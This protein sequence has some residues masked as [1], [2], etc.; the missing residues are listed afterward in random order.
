MFLRGESIPARGQGVEYVPQQRQSSP[1]QDGD[2]LVHLL[3][4]INQ[5]QARTVQ[6]GPHASPPRVTTRPRRN[7][8][9]G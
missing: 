5:D 2:T 7:V 8:W 9:K 6:T 1:Q 3:G 4:R